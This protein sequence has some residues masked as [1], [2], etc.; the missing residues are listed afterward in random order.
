ME[1]APDGLELYCDC[2]LRATSVTLG[3]QQRTPSARAHTSVCTSTCVSPTSVH[4]HV[5]R[6]AYMHQ[7]MCSG[8]L[9]T[10]PLHAE[11]SPPR[12][13][14]AMPSAY[15]GLQPPCNSNQLIIVLLAQT[16]SVKADG[17]SPCYSRKAAGHPP[18]HRIAAT[19]QAPPQL[20]QLLLLVCVFRCGVS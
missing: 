15:A 11:G 13:S 2:A 12:G 16:V 14:S 4:G 8:K 7:N 5:L 18:C 9:S 17:C 10:P 1:R 19:V 3:G 20:V 6:S